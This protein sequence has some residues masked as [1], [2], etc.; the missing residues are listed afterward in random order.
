MAMEALLATGDVEKRQKKTRKEVQ[1]PGYFVKKKLG[2]GTQAQVFKAVRTNEVG[3]VIGDADV[4]VKIFN[5]RGAFD[6]IRRELR[7]LET[8]QGHPNI[9][10][11]VDSIETETVNAIVLELCR[12]DLFSLTK[13]YPLKENEAVDVMYGVLS[14][15]QHLHTLRIVHRDIKPENVAMGNDGKPRLMD[16]GIAADVTDEVA[17]QYHGGSIG[18]MAPELVARKPYGLKVDVFAAGAT[19]YYILSQQKPFDTPSMTKESILAKT[20]MC[21]VPFGPCFDHVSDASKFIIQRMMHP[22]PAKRPAAGVALTLSPFATRVADTNQ[23][24]GDTLREATRDLVDNLSARDRVLSDNKRSSVAAEADN[25]EEARSSF[26]NVRP[27]SAVENNSREGAN[28]FIKCPTPPKVTGGEARPSRPTPQGLYQ[29]RARPEVASLVAPTAACMAPNE[30]AAP[31]VEESV[32]DIRRWR[33]ALLSMQ[34][35]EEPENVFSECSKAHAAG[36]AKEQQ[37]I[38]SH[39]TKDSLIEMPFLGVLAPD[40]LDMLPELE[41]ED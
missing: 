20:M 24:R 16:F 33:M 1:C 2:Y 11:L 35:V 29:H 7:M 18:Y 36:D 8:V 38:F 5:A 34:K 41:L 23:V 27:R 3:E 31:L 25:Q 4:A 14:A 26:E 37:N 6:N 15:T 30:T 32:D 13:Y 19:F 10:Q 17:M 9:V 40:T 28:S 21:E 39:E 22:A 12:K